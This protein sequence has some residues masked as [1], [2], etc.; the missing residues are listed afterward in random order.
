LRSRRA[1]PGY[2]PPQS[3]AGHPGIRGCCHS[4]RGPGGDQPRRSTWTTVPARTAADST[5]PGAPVSPYRLL[6]QAATPQPARQRCV[7]RLNGRTALACGH[8]AIDEARWRPPRVDAAAQVAVRLN[9]FIS[10]RLVSRA[11]ASCAPPSSTA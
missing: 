3:R 6:R 7:P 2:S 8:L 1:I 11:A 9:W 4:L 5:L 10:R